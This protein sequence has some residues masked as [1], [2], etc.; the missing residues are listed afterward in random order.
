MPH[1]RYTQ[2]QVC[3]KAQA[4][5]EDDASYASTTKEQGRPVLYDDRQNEDWKD[6]GA[7]ALVPSTVWRW[8]SW[9][10]GLTQTVQQASPS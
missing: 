9:L 4:Y 10:A 6:K 2:E 7:P 1:K 8:L 5:L 3:Q